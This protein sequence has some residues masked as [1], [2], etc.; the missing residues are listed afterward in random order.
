MVEVNFTPGSSAAEALNRFT[1]DISVLFCCKVVCP[2]MPAHYRI[3]DHGCWS[4]FPH[5][6]SLCFNLIKR[7][8]FCPKRIL[9][10]NYLCSSCLLSVHNSVLLISVCPTGP[11]Y[12]VMLC[13][14]VADPTAQRPV[15][16]SFPEIPPLLSNRQYLSWGGVTL[17]RAQMKVILRN[18]SDNQTLNLR[19]IVRGPDQDCFQLQNRFGREELLGSSMELQLR[20][21]EDAAVRLLFTPTRHACLLAKLDIKQLAQRA[22]LHSVKF[23]IPL[24]GYGGMSHLVVEGATAT[25]D[26]YSL[27]L[28]L[29]PGDSSHF[30]RFRLHNTGSRAAF[31]RA[32]VYKTLTS[33]QLSS[34]ALH[35]TDNIVLSSAILTNVTLRSLMSESRNFTPSGGRN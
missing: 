31:V 5:I 17:G 20:Q 9:R 22:S 12:E 34:P 24:T 18:S 19:L 33:S 6:L 3:I 35:S 26:G 28:G 4:K 2:F 16:P 32:V 25:P 30:A 21:Q 15:S 29:D 10:Y 1:R 13:G 7:S 14:Q 23:T 11:T 27:T 8:A